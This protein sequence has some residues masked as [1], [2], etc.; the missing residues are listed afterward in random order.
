MSY[1]KWEWFHDFPD[2]PVVVYVELDKERWTKRVL[3]YFQDGS[4]AWADEREELGTML[5]EEPYPPDWEIN[6]SGE[7]FIQPVTQ[8][9]FEAR[10][11]V[12]KPAP[13]H[14]I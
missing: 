2:E 10:W 3:E 8:E 7:F 6:E 11:A 13:L 12:R 9:E 1:Y 5:G 4:Q 14:Q